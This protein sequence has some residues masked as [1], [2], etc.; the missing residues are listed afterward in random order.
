MLLKKQKQTTKPPKQVLW[1]DIFLC[2]QMVG[3]EEHPVLLPS[4][5]AIP[6]PTFPLA[7]FFLFHTY[8]FPW[9]TSGW[10][11]ELCAHSGFVPLCWVFS[12]G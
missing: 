8:L 4:V 12:V 7:P 10:C 5:T 11:W 1:S 6:H 3:P 9:Q 2:L